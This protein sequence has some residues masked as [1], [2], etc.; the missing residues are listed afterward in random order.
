MKALYL[1]SDRRS[2]SV[3][4]RPTTSQRRTLETLS[5][6]TAPLL[7]EIGQQVLR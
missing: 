2:R 3:P 7:L 4:V 5:R 6:I 1:C